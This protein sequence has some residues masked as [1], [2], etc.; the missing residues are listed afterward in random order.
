MSVKQMENEL[1]NHYDVLTNAQANANDNTNVGQANKKPDDKPGYES[2]DDRMGA[3]PFN[4]GTTLLFQFNDNSYRVGALHI[5]T[6]E[7]FN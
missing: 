5:T 6:K 3:S 7:D 1:I 4:E 2:L